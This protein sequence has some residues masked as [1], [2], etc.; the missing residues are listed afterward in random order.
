VTRTS[1]ALAL[2]LSLGALALASESPANAFHKA[3]DGKDE[4]ART[5]AVNELAKIE[6]RVVVALLAYPASQDPSANVRKAAIKALGAQ[7]SSGPAAVALG[8]ALHVDD[9]PAEVT[10]AIVHALGS[11]GADA[12]VAPLVKLLKTRP[13]IYRQGGQN[14]KDIVDATGP[15]ID[16]LAKDASAL[17][18]AD[19]IDFL[20]AEEP[21]AQLRGKRN[22]AVNSDPLLRKAMAALTALTGETYKS[23]EDWQDWWTNTGVHAKGVVVCRCEIT[24][25][26]YDKPTGKQVCPGCGGAVDKCSEL[27]RTRYANVPLAGDAETSQK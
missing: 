7:W 1:L 21:G 27:L 17:A 4:A 5:A 9:D 15:V 6:S 12:A 18:T 26:L 14:A 19:L 16:A 3:Y 20:S 8:K 24:G 23:P 2:V 25:K 11:T 22:K 10:L 13:R